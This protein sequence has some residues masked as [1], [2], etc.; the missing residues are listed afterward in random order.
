MFTEARLMQNNG[1]SMLSDPI[2][3]NIGEWVMK[4]IGKIAIAKKLPDNQKASII[5]IENGDAAT[6]Y[7]IRFANE[8]DA[9]ILIGISDGE[10]NAID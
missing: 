10:E 8:N 7:M 3:V 5:A 4:N 9:V 2:T 1:L 6:P